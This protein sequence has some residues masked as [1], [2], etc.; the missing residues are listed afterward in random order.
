[1]RTDTPPTVTATREPTPDQPLLLK[2]ED[3]ARLLKLS[4]AATYRLV[5]SGALPSVRIGGCRRIVPDELAA[6]I[7]NLIAQR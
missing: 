5:A 3:A 2:V 4:R 1:V 7:A 6:Y